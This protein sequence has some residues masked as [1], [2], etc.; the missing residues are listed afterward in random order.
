MSPARCADGLAGDPDSPL[1][2][3]HL[4]QLLDVAE[5]TLARTI[6]ALEEDGLIRADPE[7]G[8]II[9]M[10]DRHALEQAFRDW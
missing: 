6:N 8:G 2:Q 9:A 7:T 1:K 4:A 10:T 3:R 5:E